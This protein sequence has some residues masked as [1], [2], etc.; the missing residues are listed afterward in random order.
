MASLA[1][2]LRVLAAFT[3][4][5]PELG[6]GELARM[7]E[8]D[9]RRTQR[10]VSTLY[11]LGYLEQDPQ[12]RRYRPGVCVLT[13]GYAA[14]QS[15]DLRQ[16]ARPHLVA[17]I[18]Q[19]GQSVNLAVRHRAEVMF[20]DCLRGATYRLGVNVHIGDRLPIQLS[21]LGKAMLA[22]LPEQERAEVIGEIR[23]QATTEYAAA[24]P[25]ELQEMLAQTRE[26]GFA[27]MDQETTLG[28]RSVAAPLMSPDGYPVAAVNVVMPTPLVSMAEMTQTVAPALVET[29]ARISQLLPAGAGNRHLTGPASAELL[30]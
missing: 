9:K 24:S 4:D 16:L 28:V 20:I 26:R 7:L 27:V 25:G 15:L 23:F 21:S 5:R 10:L 18:E 19:F 3:A 29:A 17:L 1:A 11:D 8:M 13:L 12:T 14:L 22:Y 6:V 30:G 2:G